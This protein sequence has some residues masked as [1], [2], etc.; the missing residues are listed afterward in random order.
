MLRRSC[1]LHAFLEKD[2]IDGRSAGRRECSAG[3][4]CRPLQN[5]LEGGAFQIMHLV[6]SSYQEKS[7]KAWCLVATRKMLSS[8]SAERGQLQGLCCFSDYAPVV[9]GRSAHRL[10]KDHRCT[11]PSE[12]PS[13]SAAAPAPPIKLP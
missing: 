13:S 12:M 11:L 5:T 7:F 1:F 2:Q 3:K 9:V 6:P 4:H 8:P 10:D